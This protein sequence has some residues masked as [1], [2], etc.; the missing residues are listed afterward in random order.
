MALNNPDTE[1]WAS[2]VLGSLV[3]FR[4]AGFAVSDVIAEA[5][6][7]ALVLALVE[8]LMLADND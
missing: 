5:D 1:D 2:P 8:T 7:E 6:V 4:F 3:A